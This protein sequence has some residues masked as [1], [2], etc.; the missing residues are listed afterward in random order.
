MAQIEDL[1]DAGI[2]LIEDTQRVKIDTIFTDKSVVL[3]GTL[4]GMSRDDAKEILEKMG[5]KVVGS[6]SSKTDFVLAGENAGSKL[7]K[8]NSLGINIIDLDFLKNEM[9]KYD[10]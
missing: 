3:T 9:K 1:F 4:D 6:V 7:D 8:A 5:A 2:V 10:I